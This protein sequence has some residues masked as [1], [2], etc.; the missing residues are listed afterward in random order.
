MD[1]TPLDGSSLHMDSLLAAS[2]PV[3][4]VP[5]TTHVINPSQIMMVRLQ[6]LNAVCLKQTDPGTSRRDRDRAARHKLR[7]LDPDKYVERLA[8]RREKDRER[9]QFER[10][11]GAVVREARLERRRVREREQRSAETQEQ[12]TER[13]AKR[14]SGEI[15]RVLKQISTMD[16]VD[17]DQL[18]PQLGNTPL[19]TPEPTGSHVLNDTRMPAQIPQAHLSEH[20]SRMRYSSCSDEIDRSHEA[21]SGPGSYTKT[22]QTSW[23]AQQSLMTLV[24]MATGCETL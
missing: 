5:P 15:R 10:G 9:R 6:P 7:Q 2:L 11:K 24:H 20:L 3:L 14:R 4:T 23:V 12:R 18:T 1:S 16:Q 17:R 8:S 21:C 13:L 19:T 22:P